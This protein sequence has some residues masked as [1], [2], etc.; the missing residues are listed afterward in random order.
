MS[1]EQYWQDAMKSWEISE[2]DSPTPWDDI[3]EAKPPKVD[4][5]AG[6]A[7]E[8]V[9]RAYLTHG[10]ES[11]CEYLDAQARY[12][13]GFAQVV[14]TLLALLRFNDWL[15]G[16]YGAGKKRPD[17]SKYYDDAAPFYVLSQLCLKVTDFS[18]ENEVQRLKALYLNVRP[19]RVWFDE[20]HGGGMP[21]CDTWAQGHDQMMFELTGKTRE[22]LYAEFE[23]K[24]KAEKE[25]A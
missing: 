15:D 16:C 10:Y 11:H 5:V 12:E 2:Y 21:W 14:N 4:D 13:K 7:A 18:D 1:K 22:Q 25:A 24:H 8:N 3:H 17:F 9:L 20:F 23:K 6:E 19:M